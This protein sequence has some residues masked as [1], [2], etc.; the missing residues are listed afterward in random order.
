M[1]LS[2]SKDI[3]LRYQCIHKPSAFIPQTSN[4]LTLETIDEDPTEFSLYF[5]NSWTQGGQQC[6]Q[7]PHRGRN[8][9]LLLESAIPHAGGCRHC[10]AN[11]RATLDWREKADD[12]G[13]FLGF[14]NW[15]HD[16]FASKRNVYPSLLC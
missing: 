7:I 2:Q 3:H 4:E 9:G 5:H 12:L 8:L 14:W 10:E 15:P 16:C 11:S 1:W 13:F 6:L